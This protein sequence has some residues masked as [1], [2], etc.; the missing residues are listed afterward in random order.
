MPRMT[1]QVPTNA[2]AIAPVPAARK[3]FHCRGATKASDLDKF[4]KSS[5]QGLNI[6]IAKAT[7]FSEAS[8]NEL[9]NDYRKQSLDKANAWLQ[10]LSQDVI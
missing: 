6:V 4:R 5:E 10:E 9:Y 1:T 8:N 2:N 3:I 7:V